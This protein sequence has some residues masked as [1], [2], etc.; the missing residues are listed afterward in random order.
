MARKPALKKPQQF[1][2]FIIGF[3]IFDDGKLADGDMYDFG[4][5]PKLGTW[6]YM[7]EVRVLAEAKPRRMKL[8]TITLK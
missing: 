8:P 4:E 1:H 5:E 3:D 7:F 6:N 2:R